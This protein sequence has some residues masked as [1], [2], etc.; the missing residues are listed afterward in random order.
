MGRGGRHT[1]AANGGKWLRPYKRLALLLR[2]D[3]TCAY[4]LQ[5]FSNGLHI[6]HY[7]RVED[8][9]TNEATNL[10]VA[11]RPCNSRKQNLTIRQWYEVL[12]A[13]GVDTEKVRRRAKRLMAKNL[14]PYRAR[15]VRFHLVLSG[16]EIGA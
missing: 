14:S 13:K 16:G 10:I 3:F 11:C 2:D 8:G 1:P 9:G 4:C 6:D 12:R 5:K 15:A 7:I